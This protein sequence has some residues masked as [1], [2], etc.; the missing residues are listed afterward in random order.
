MSFQ[1]PHDPLPHGFLCHGFFVTVLCSKRV[2]ILAC[3]GHRTAFRNCFFPSTTW[4][5][6]TGVARL[7]DRHLYLLS[8]LSSL[9]FVY[10]KVCRTPFQAANLSSE[11]LPGLP[12]HFWN[13]SPVCETNPDPFSTELRCVLTSTSLILCMERRTGFL[14]NLARCLV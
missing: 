14:E 3:D 6:Q 11:M 5:D 2:Y 7:G 12:L 9:L 10:S 4:G 8:H 13:M 1:N